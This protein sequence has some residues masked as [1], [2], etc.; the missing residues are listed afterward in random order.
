MMKKVVLPTLAIALMAATLMNGCSDWGDGD[1]GY[2]DGPQ[3]TD[4]AA[5]D[6]HTYTDNLAAK[7]MN[8]DSVVVSYIPHNNT[9]SVTHY[10]MPLD[11]GSGE[12]IVTTIER[13]GDTITVTENVG[14]QG[15]TNC[16]C[17]Y[18]NTFHIAY[19]PPRPFTLVI[20]VVEDFFGTTH[21]AIVYQQT[22]E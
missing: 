6:C 15:R 19:L 20:K 18:D 5:S 7:D 14:E 2:P 1:R 8:T 22:F 3:L 10:N 12:H 17:L 21:Q 4:V 13:M 9:M 11:C 16:V